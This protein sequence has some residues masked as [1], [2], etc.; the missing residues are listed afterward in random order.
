MTTGASLSTTSGTTAAT[1]AAQLELHLL[2]QPAVS[3]HGRIAANSAIFFSGLYSRTRTGKHGRL[4]VDKR[5]AER[6]R[7]QRLHQAYGQRLLRGLDQLGTWRA[8][9]Q[10]SGTSLRIIPGIWPK[11]FMLRVPEYCRCLALRAIHSQEL[12]CIGKRGQYTSLGTISSFPQYPDVWPHLLSSRHATPAQQYT[13]R[14]GE[15][16]A[17]RA[18][19]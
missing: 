2:L 5:P 9:R 17:T 13:K 8:F 1:T 10:M 18:R 3:H 6:H 19:L 11:L 4:L 16:S 12:L 14:A 7:C 15:P